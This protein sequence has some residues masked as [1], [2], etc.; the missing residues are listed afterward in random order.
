MGIIR[1]IYY[2]TLAPFCENTDNDPKYAQIVDSLLRLES[3]LLEK[4]A[5]HKDILEKYQD[6]HMEL[7]D[8][9][10][11]VNFE[12]GFKVGMRIAEEAL[13]D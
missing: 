7:A 9:T 4:C 5:E 12:K 13:K 6:T 11:Y 1:D 3:E 8:H 2:G 10:A